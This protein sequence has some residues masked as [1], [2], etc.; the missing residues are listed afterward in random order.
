MAFPDAWLDELLAKND[1]VSVVSPYVELRP[2]G[3]RLWGLCPLHGEKTPSFSVS[4]DK[5]MF[6]C[7]GCHAGG[8]AIQFIMQMERLSFVEA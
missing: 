7:F 5:Q 3:R 6:Y 1:I 4:P 8:T 2:K